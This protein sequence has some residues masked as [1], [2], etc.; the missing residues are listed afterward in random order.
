MSNP[1]DVTFSGSINGLTEQGGQVGPVDIA[2]QLTGQ[3]YTFEAKDFPVEAAAALP[4]SPRVMAL[5]AIPVGLQQSLLIIKA[6]GA[7]EFT[8]NGGVQVYTAGQGGPVVLS[9]DPAAVTI[10]FGNPNAFEVRVYV[11]Q[12]VGA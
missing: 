11:L 5:P 4:G 9:G 3:K 7:V 12:V 1:G 2:Y 10:E 6:S 8:I